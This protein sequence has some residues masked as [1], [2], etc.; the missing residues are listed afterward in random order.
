MNWLSR[1]IRRSRMET[2]L[3]KEIRFH[4]DQHAADLEKHGYDRAEALRLARLELGGPEQVK[5]GCRDARGARWL[6]DFWQDIRY[7]IRG[8]RKKPGFTAVALLTLALGAGATTVMFT[9]VDGVMLKPLPYPEPGRL[10]ALQ[11]QTDWSTHFGNLWAFTFANYLDCKRESR[12]LDMAALRFGGGTVKVHGAAE[13]IDSLEISAN[14]FSV[15]RT[16]LAS[17]RAFLS[18]EDQHGARP[19][20]IVSDTFARRHFDGKV[21]GQT[22]VFDEKTYT[23]I[24]SAPK[25]FR[26]VDADVDVFTPIG[27]NTSPRLLN[28]GI[29]SAQVIARLRPGVTLEQARTDLAITGRALAERF[30]QT[31]HGRTFIADPLRRNAGDAKSTLWLLMGAVSLVLLIACVNVAS[32]LLTRAISRERE[33]AMRVALGARRGRLVRQCL[34][35]GAVLATA[36]GS[37]GVLFAALGSKPFAAIWPGALPR[38][39]E[40][41][42]D[43]RVL[44][45]ALAASLVSG[46]AFGLAPALRTPVRN[47]EKALRSG[48]R[49]VT[50]RLRGLHA[51]FVIAEIALAMV[52]L[53]CAGTLGRTLLRL[54]GLDP[55]VDIHNVLTARVALPPS[56]LE[57]V[58]RT[59]AAWQDILHRGRGTPGVASIALVDTVPMRQGN[60]QIAF[61]TSPATPEAQRPI[62]L[63]TC[64]T[65]EYLKVMGLEV[66]QGRFF[67]ERDQPNTAPVVVVD[68]TLARQAFGGGS[69][70]GRQMWIEGYTDPLRIIGVVGHVRHWGLAQ[71]DQNQVRAQIYYPFAQLPD[72]FVRR[73]S[74]LMSIA[75][76]TKAA[77][78][79]AFQA[80]KREV[81]GTN[82]D[83][84]L[85][86]M[87]TM[88]QL[89]A[90]TLARQRFL[91]V[92][93]GIFSAV[94]LLLA[95][96]GIYGVMAYLTSQRIP[97]M[98][99]RMAMG[100]NRRDVIRIVL[101][102]GLTMIGI[103]VVAGAGAAI[104]AEQLLRHNVAG[105]QGYEPAALVIMALTLIAAGLLASFVPARRASRIDPMQALRTE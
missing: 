8:F 9:V 99:L 44:T 76:R 39:A 65:P 95:C 27:E 79:A 31:N 86:G 16:P 11:E 69:A 13:Y 21:V 18:E 73:W 57:N 52:L 1:L 10:L 37:L 29:H 91:L 97:E 32:L 12:T 60:N 47:L 53:A 89:A 68:E 45:F 42:V 101:A 24:G 100:A 6:E 50:G 34:T 28:R 88:E 71:D 72:R 15:L 85:Y 36:G 105:V 40:I 14:L 19:V 61:W 92:L 43:W 46:L 77:P 26:P 33:L 58:A 56:T 22:L 30:P 96:V 54:S 5:E 63:A 2:Q 49:S 25:N 75:V 62:A 64:V 3:D 35:E 7:A 102:E 70:L 90:S 48:A 87:W 94:A 20:M 23:V 59:R 74:E 51:A 38:A 93:F 82:G 81:S 103:G 78:Q 84:A 98:G 55:G 4:L 83:R 66:R 67:D 41:G 104:G 80:L 17:G